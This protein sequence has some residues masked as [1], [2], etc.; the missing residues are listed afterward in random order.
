MA[1]AA[2]ILK[3]GVYLREYGITFSAEKIYLGLC[4]DGLD[5]GV[6]VAIP[7]LDGLVRRASASSQDVVLP[8]APS[9]GLDCRF[10]LTVYNAKKSYDGDFSFHSFIMY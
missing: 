8:R 6:V 2:Y 7:H 3:V 4:V 9:Q 5:E 1:T 10:V